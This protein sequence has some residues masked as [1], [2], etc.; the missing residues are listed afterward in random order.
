MP[1]DELVT[2]MALISMR[3]TLEKALEAHMDRN[4]ARRNNCVRNI[5]LNCYNI[6]DH[7]E[8]NKLGGELQDARETPEC[9]P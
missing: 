8:R 2:Q 3:N 4:V 9:S 1:D 5:W 7:N 6:L